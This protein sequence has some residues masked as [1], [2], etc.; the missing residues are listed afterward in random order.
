MYMLANLF[1][2]F[3]NTVL[4]CTDKIDTKSSLIIIKLF[5]LKG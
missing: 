5:N 1:F 2:Y 3:R 4:L